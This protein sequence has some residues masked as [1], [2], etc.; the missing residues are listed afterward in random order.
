MEKKCLSVWSLDAVLSID[1][2][3]TRW[4]LPVGLVTAAFASFPV[5]GYSLWIP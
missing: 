5:L 1:T 4:S 3:S 2:R